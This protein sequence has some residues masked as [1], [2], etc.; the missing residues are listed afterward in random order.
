M[1]DPSSTAD[2]IFTSGSS[3]YP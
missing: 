2:N 3:V 1:T